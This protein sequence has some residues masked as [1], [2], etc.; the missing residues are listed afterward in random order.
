MQSGV[1]VAVE[2]PLIGEPRLKS[3]AKVVTNVDL[4]KAGGWA[5]GGEF[6]SVGGI[7]DLIA[8]S[9][10]L[11]YGERGSRGNPRP[12]ARVYTVNPDST[13]SLHAE[14]EGGTWARTLRD[15]VIELLEQESSRPKERPWDENLIGYSDEALRSELARRHQPH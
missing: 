15:R 10:L 8:P 11:V 1:T 12:Q 14:A 9:V 13:L 5:Y 2:V 3:W 6:L 7:Q 4:E